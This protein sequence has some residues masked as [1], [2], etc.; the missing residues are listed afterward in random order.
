MLERSVAGAVLGVVLVRFLRALAAPPLGWDDLTYHL[1]KAGRFVQA[2]GFTDVAA[3]DAWGAYGFFPVAGEILW[4]WAMLPLHDDC[5]LAPASLLIWCLAVLGV[6]AAARQLGARVRPAFLAAL[7]VGAMPAALAYVGTGYVDNLTLAGVALGS[8]FVVRVARGGPPREAPLAVAALALAGGTKLLAM[9]ILALGGA[10]VLWRIA[11]SPA[12]PRARAGACA[13][14]LL[15]ASVAAPTYVRAWIERGSPLYPVPLHVA[16]VELSAGEPE[17]AEVTRRILESP[18]LHVPLSTSIGYLVSRN[19]PSG[20]FLNPGPGGLLL[21][22]LAVAGVPRLE[23]RTLL[24]GS[25]LWLVAM[26][27]LGAYA[28]G[29]MEVFRTASMVMTSGRYLTPA[30]GALGALA[31]LLHRPLPRALTAIAAAVGALLPTPVAWSEVDLRATAWVLVHR[32]GLG[33]PLGARAAPPPAPALDISSRP[34]F[35]SSW[36][37]SRRWEWRGP[38]DLPLP[39][40]RGRGRPDRPA[41]HAPPRS[42]RA[43][44]A[45]GRS[46]GRSTRPAA[47]ARGRRRLRRP[48]SQLVPLPAARLPARE[49]GSLRAGDR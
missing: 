36:P 2:G 39:A 30:F 10:V 32:P 33:G 3:P 41:L 37:A 29:A 40:L 34:P 17:S 4:S 42:I 22:L 13:A 31:A 8:V 24:A 19:A 38:P 11:R 21:L 44:P 35:C 46:G 43:T 25:Y 1:L 48:G 9:P 5:L 45:P 28:S 18:H 16:G 20:A 7:A 14:L 23:R 26:V 15:A 47:G 49:P 27:L 12:S 6:S